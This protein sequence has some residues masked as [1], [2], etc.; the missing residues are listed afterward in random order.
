[1]ALDT[2]VVVRINRR[3]GVSTL[4]PLS[5]CCRL[6]TSDKCCDSVSPSAAWPAACA[7]RC[8]IINWPHSGLGRDRQPGR[9]LAPATNNAQSNVTW[10]GR[11]QQNTVAIT[12]SSAARRGIPCRTLVLNSDRLG[13]ASL[14]CL[15]VNAEGLIS[16]RLWRPTS[17]PLQGAVTAGGSWLAA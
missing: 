3:N 13:M 11:T 12:A 9:W 16:A 14:R 10:Q 8:I 2:Q 7:K 1:M 15:T 4:R 6:H 17:R 5:C